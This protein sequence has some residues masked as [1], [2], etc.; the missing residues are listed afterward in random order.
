ML[1][2]LLLVYAS[3]HVNQQQLTQL[4]RYNSLFCRKAEKYMSQNVNVSL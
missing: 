1:T 3:A 4:Y 2:E